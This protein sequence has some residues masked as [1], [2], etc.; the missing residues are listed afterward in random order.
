MIKKSMMK[1]TLLS[2]TMGLSMWSAPIS[3]NVA[4]WLVNGNPTVAIS[5]IAAPF[6][7]S[8]FGGGSWVG[9]TSNDG[10][11]A[12]STAAG[13]YT[14]TLNIGAVIGTAGTLSLQYAAD[15]TVAWSISNGSLSGDTLCSSPD[16]FTSV[17]GA[18]RSLTGT[19]AANSILTA[20]VNNLDPGPTGL[21]VAG[22]ASAFSPV[23]EPGSVTMI[24]IGGAAL[25][26]ARL[27]RKK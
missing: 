10:N 18:P 22:E 14:Y 27:R 25:A 6:W 17:G 2:L 19:F 3:T 23:P 24:A 9:T 12:G 26:L 4:S 8:N 1:L 20:T 15:N 21:L 7:I 13:T 5:P 16:C 11:L